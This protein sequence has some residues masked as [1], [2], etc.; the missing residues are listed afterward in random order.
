MSTSAER[1]LPNGSSRFH[2]NFILHLPTSLLNSYVTDNKTATRGLT[3]P[4]GQ[5]L[6]PFHSTPAHN[7]STSNTAK[8]PRS[9]TSR[10]QIASP[11]SVY[12]PPRRHSPQSAS[13]AVQ[14]R[15]YV[16]MAGVAG[17]GFGCLRGSGRQRRLLWI[18]GVWGRG[19]AR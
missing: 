13:T 14:L 12:H 8:I 7:P 3:K 10:T 16:S 9:P 4:G 15:V 1:V 18:E 17:A 2:F 6:L 5:L 19:E 11:L